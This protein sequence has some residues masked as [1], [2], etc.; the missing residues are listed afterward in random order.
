M[1]AA[2]ADAEEQEQKAKAAAAAADAEAHGAK[3]DAADAERAPEETLR[4]WTR[5]A[6][7]DGS[8]AERSGGTPDV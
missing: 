7:N 4:I 3:A 8:E 5:D 1:K 2:E 6:A